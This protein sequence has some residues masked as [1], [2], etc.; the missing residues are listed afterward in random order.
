MKKP[1]VTAII[2]T[3]NRNSATVKRALDSVVKQSYENMEILLINDCPENRELAQEIKELADSYTGK[4][5]YIEMPENSGACAA[6]NLGISNSSGEFVAFLDDDDEWLENKISMQ[7]KYF[8]DDS[9]GMVYCNTYARY[10]NKNKLVIRERHRMPEG[11]VYPYLFERNFISSTS[12]PMIRKSAIMQEKG[13]N[14]EMQSLQDLELWLRITRNWRVRYIHE[15]LG[16][17]YFYDGERISKHTERRTA[18]YEI[19]YAQH[20]KYLEDNP[21]IM[22]SYERTGMTFYVNAGDFKR[23]YGHL[24]KAV[25]TDPLSIGKNLFCTAKFIIRLFVRPKIL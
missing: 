22:A 16:I 5:R 9:T 23:A 20:E 19:I 4:V 12:F 18:A 10:E 3:Y 1:L 6:R 17:Y 25:L 2:T 11:C 21:K 8:D 13:F 7:I 15:P 24:K 14:T